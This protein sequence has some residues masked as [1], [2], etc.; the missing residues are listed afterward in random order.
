MKR[1]RTV[2]YRSDAENPAKLKGLVPESHA[3]IDC[4]VNTAPRLL[5]R[6]ELEDAFKAHDHVE[7][8][9]D[10]H[11]EVFMVHNAIWKEAGMDP[12]EGCLCIGCLEWWLGR[13]LEPKDFDRDHEFNRMPGTRRLP[14]RRGDERL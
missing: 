1:F 13:R 9:I 5:D 2:S 6:R 14:E 11:S 10:E 12:M 7:Q 3:C 4:A 8:W